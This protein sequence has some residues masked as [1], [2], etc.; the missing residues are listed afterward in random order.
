MS[1]KNSEY[2]VRDRRGDVSSILSKIVNKSHAFN[3][4]K[5]C[6][7]HFFSLLKSICLC[8][9]CHEIYK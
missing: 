5:Q 3:N 2:E 9:Q 8:V 6:W 4:I 7:L 1:I